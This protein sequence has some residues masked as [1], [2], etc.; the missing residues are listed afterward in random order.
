M[1]SIIMALTLAL[2]LLTGFAADDAKK[3][4]YTV[5]MTGVT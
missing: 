5:G 4:T 3:T 2:G 1:K